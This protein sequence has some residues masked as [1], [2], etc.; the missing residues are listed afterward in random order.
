MRFH[1]RASLSSLL[2]ALG[3][4]LAL[5]GCGD[6]AKQPENELR[7]PGQSS[8]RPPPNLPWKPA[9]REYETAPAVGDPIEQT[10]AY[11]DLKNIDRKQEGWRV[12]LPPP[13]K[14]TFPAGKKL[15]WTLETN[16]GRMVAE[17]W[18]EIA[19]LHAANI[20]YLTRLGFFDGLVFHR[21]IQGFMAQGGDPLGNG[22]GMPGYAL[23]LEVKKGVGHDDIGVLSTANYGQPDTDGSQFFIMF[24]QRPQLDG[25]YSVFGKVLEGLDTVRAIEAV[26]A[27]RDPGTPRE[28]VAIE[29]ATV[30]WR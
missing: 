18:H 29:R 19:P 13:A 8:R 25:G 4:A 28:R 15:Y 24:R 5:P 23:P 11:I 27:L 6:P 16:K 22:K 9:M 10:D 17:I 7:I 26:G 3:C 12:R 1:S 14:L 20:A 21:I 2:F 30:E